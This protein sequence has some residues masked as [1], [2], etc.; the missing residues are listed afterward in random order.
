[1]AQGPTIK[2]SSIVNHNLVPV[3]G[4]ILSPTPP[5]ME[6]L[7]PG[8]TDNKSSNFITNWFPVQTK[9]LCS[10]HTQINIDHQRTNKENYYKCQPYLIVIGAGLDRISLLFKRMQ[11]KLNATVSS[12]TSFHLPLYSL[13]RGSLCKLKNAALLN[14]TQYFHLYLEGSYKT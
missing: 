11:E 12:D 9:I 5:E 3:Q 6:S 14:L 8:E 1:M 7:F 4:K 13:H 10:N 2:K